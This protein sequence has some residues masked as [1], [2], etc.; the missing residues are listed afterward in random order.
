[1]TRNITLFQAYMRTAAQTAQSLGMQH[2]GKP[3]QEID[4]SGNNFYQVIYTDNS[5][6]IVFSPDSER[7]I[8]VDHHRAPRGHKR[9]AT[10]VH[11]EP[12]HGS[13][14][15]VHSSSQPVHSSS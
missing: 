3:V 10:A 9:Q 12:V 2:A 14:Q 5:S 6:V 15:P 13:S 11:H 4:F 7:P 1:M 8:T